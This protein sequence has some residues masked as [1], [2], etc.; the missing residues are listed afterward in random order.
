[1]ETIHSIS[2]PE[3]P[4]LAWVSGPVNG[5]MRE[6]CPRQFGG[7]AEVWKKAE[8]EIA[9]S[10]GENDALRIGERL[11]TSST[12]EIIQVPGYP[13]VYDYEWFPQDQDQQYTARIVITAWKFFS[14]VD[15]VL[16]ATTSV[17]E[18][19]TTD[20]MNE[21]VSGL[22]KDF[23]SVGFAAGVIQ[24]PE[25]P[26][27]EV[28]SKVVAFLDKTQQEFGVNSAIYI[29]FGTYWWPLEP[30]KL[31]VLIDE[32]ITNRKPFL[33]THT[34]PLAHVPEDISSRIAASGF[35]LE[36]AWAPQDM[37][38]KHPA[39]GWFVTHGGWNSVQESFRYG[40]PLIF[41]PLSADQPMNAILVTLEHRAG[42]ELMTVRTGE[43]GMMK[44]YRLAAS[45]NSDDAT[46][47]SLFT[48]EAFRDEVNGLLSKMNSEEGQLVRNN[49]E[50]LQKEIA[51]VWDAGGE[52]KRELERFF[53]KYV[54]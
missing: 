39:T 24:S 10:Y 48:V 47:S 21:Y 31:Y 15:G 9:E 27:N 11:Y 26:R 52:A 41:W 14:E 20:A 23:I 36:I 54:D 5:T 2:P 22:G 6:F 42:F 19:G 40:V 49:V 12:G 44:P 17:L 30:T 38:L 25:R 28:E 53:L 50:R 35:G 3:L 32:L 33:F 4:V 13:P 8:Q 34:S 51:K 46:S 29:A 45:S 18:K 1:M 7:R 16:S 43:R 37:I